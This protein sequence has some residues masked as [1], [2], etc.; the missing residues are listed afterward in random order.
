M[1]IKF[2]KAAIEA[3]LADGFFKKMIGLSFSKKK[4][5]LFTMDFEY[6]WQFWMFGVRY[7]LYMIFLDKNKIV[8]DV[9]KA[10]PL[11][12]DMKTWKVYAPKKPAKY[13]LETPYDIKMKIGDRLSW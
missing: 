1:K 13:I 8:V 2:K 7:D 6:A 11:S 4:N 5:M 12:F 10:V 9:R 3:D